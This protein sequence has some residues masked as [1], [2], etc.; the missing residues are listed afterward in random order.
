MKRIALMLSVVAAV[1]GLLTG[2]GESEEQ[3]QT[4][5]KF[6]EIREEAILLP[7]DVKKNFNEIFAKP[8]SPIKNVVG[9]YDTG[10]KL[11][12]SHSIYPKKMTVTTAV[13]DSNNF[14]LDVTY[15]ITCESENDAAET[16]LKEAKSLEERYDL[17][18]KDLDARKIVFYESQNSPESKSPR[19]TCTASGKF[20]R[21]F[22]Y[23]APRP[24]WPENEQNAKLIT[25]A[26]GL[27]LG[28]T[29]PAEMTHPYADEKFIPKKTLS[30][31]DI[32][33]VQKNFQDKTVYAISASGFY[34]DKDQLLLSLR[35]A[36]E[37]KYNMKMEHVFDPR[38]SSHTLTYRNGSREI[39]V[40]INEKFSSITYIDHALE[41]L[42]F[43][44]YDERKKNKIRKADVSGI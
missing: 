37:E 21:L 23:V 24:S 16:L 11:Y 17:I 9:I 33:K 41:E 25:G 5:K 28:K 12:Q 6:V 42:N 19:I 38:F 34:V 27:K 15:Q 10:Y 31:F 18:R 1:A 39:V 44:Q 43:K 7:T 14:I 2:C 35:K 8:F 13:A 3:Q 29:V 26:F 20:V 40:S 4:K 32:Y 22:F 30:Y 36:L